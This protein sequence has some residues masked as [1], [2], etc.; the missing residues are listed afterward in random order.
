MFWCNSTSI[1]MAVTFTPHLTQGPCVIGPGSIP[2]RVSSPQQPPWNCLQKSPASGAGACWPKSPRPIGDC[3]TC[4]CAHSAWLRGA[5]HPRH[6][7]PSKCSHTNLIHNYQVD[8]WISVPN[9]SGRGKGLKEERRSWGKQAVV[10]TGKG[11]PGHLTWCLF[12]NQ[13]PVPLQCNCAVKLPG[14]S[15]ESSILL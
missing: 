14:N 13:F 9:P 3:H 7:H 1:L 12:P 10:L 11:F 8:G 2:V 5:R 4:H 15:L 6:S